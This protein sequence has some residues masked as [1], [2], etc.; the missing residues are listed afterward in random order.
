M[1]LY[2]DPADYALDGESNV[3]PSSWWLPGTGVQRGNVFDGDA[4]G[5]KGDPATPGYPS[6]R[7]SNLKIKFTLIWL[8]Y[9]DDT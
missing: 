3:Y 7:K 4:T 1:I 9:V 6:K 2:S 8:R 5:A